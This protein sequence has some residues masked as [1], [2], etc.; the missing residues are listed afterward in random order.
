LLCGTYTEIKPVLQE[1][2]LEKGAIA[3]YLVIL[4]QAGMT[5]LGSGRKKI[6]LQASE[7]WTHLSCCKIGVGL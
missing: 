4:A 7:H 1:F 6:S 5:L 3:P 2:I